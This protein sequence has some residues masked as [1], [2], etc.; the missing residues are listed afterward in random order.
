MVRRPRRRQDLHPNRSPASAG[1]RSLPQRTRPSSAADR[2]PHCAG[3]AC[4]RAREPSCTPAR[5][6][7]RAP[8]AAIQSVTGRVALD[9]LPILSPRQHFS[10]CDSQNLTSPRLHLP[11]TTM[12]IHTPERRQFIPRP[13]DDH[14]L[15]SRV[16]RPYPNFQLLHRANLDKSDLLTPLRGCYTISHQHALATS[17]CES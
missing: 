15:P 12:D 16:A 6:Y 4:P 14:S 9:I 8:S 13:I 2:G 3:P 1:P 7:T 17:R 5:T 10:W 11:I